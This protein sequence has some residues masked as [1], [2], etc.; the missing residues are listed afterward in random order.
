[1]PKEIYINKIEY[2]HE[3]QK[4]RRELKITLS[5]KRVIRVAACYESWEQWGGTS[6][7]LYVT[8]PTVERHNT[9][10]HGGPRPEEDSN[11]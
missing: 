6:D 7:E 3:N 9:W 8:M 11:D 10:L 1:M 4:S 5:N 2:L